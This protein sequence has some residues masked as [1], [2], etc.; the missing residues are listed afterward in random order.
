[1]HADDALT[2]CH[3]RL[4]GRSGASF[5]APRPFGVG[6]PPDGVRSAPIEDAVIE[7]PTRTDRMTGRR[8]GRQEAQMTG[9]TRTIQQPANTGSILAVL[10]MTVV[11]AGAAVAIALASASAG[12]S[13]QPVAAPAPLY[14]PTVRDL[15]I[16]DQGNS[17]VTGPA[18][19]TFADH[20][21]SET[22]SA[23][24]GPK[25]DQLKDDLAVGSNQGANGY[26]GF[27]NPADRA[28]TNANG[29][30]GD[31]SAGRNLALRAQ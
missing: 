13:T 19:G 3:V 29:S 27:G 4:Q 7:R 2:R 30:N 17:S 22:G 1:V 15:G 28:S 9:T 31:A 25:G 5:K 11:I 6:L 26:H 18:A 12:K 14:A 10:G 16:R 20:G 24:F 21:W 8:L 23:G